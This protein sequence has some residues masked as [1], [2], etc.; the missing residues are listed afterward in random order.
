[1]GLFDRL[2]N[3]SSDQNDPQSG[4]KPEKAKPEAFFLDSDNSSSLGD[5]D[6]MR[7]SKTIRRTFPGTLRA[8]GVCLAASHALS[9]TSHGRRL[10]LA[11]HV[12][13]PAVPVECEF[14]AP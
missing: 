7:E 4:P 2:R 6:Y 5:R 8:D 11:L 13:D 3:S 9:W 12:C 1:M 10:A 14:L